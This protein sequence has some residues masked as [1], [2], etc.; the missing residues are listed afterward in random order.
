M[1]ISKD[2]DEQR[3]QLLTWLAASPLFA[4]SA[5]QDLL[6]QE[7]KDPKELIRN[8]TKRP[9]PM[10]WAP[11]TPMDLISNPNNIYFL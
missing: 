5:N 11:N 3:R 2:S 7:V 1:S 6:A 4:L 10:V 9:D 8:F